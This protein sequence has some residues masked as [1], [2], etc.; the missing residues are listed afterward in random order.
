MQCKNEETKKI[1][2][3]ILEIFRAEKDKLCPGSLVFHFNDKGEFKTY[4]L[5]LKNKSYSHREGLT[6]G[7][8]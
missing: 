2:K 8:K 7:K 5:H 6:K 1:E 4:E 3:E